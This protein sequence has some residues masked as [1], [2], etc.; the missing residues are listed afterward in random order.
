MLASLLMIFSPDTAAR[1][2][3]WQLTPL[4]SRVIAGWIVFASTG[5][6]CLF[7]ERRYM[8][9]RYFLPVAGVW[10]AILFTVSLFHLGDFNPGRAAT[11]IWFVLLGGLVA[12][13][14]GV[15]FYM[16]AYRRR[17]RESVPVTAS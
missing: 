16:E 7:F 11:W 3:P 12:T 15:F 5:L 13:L 2:W 8:A 4:M 9:Y 10:M 6:V 1:F 14:F 17:H